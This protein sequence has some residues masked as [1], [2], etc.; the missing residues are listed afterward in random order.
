MRLVLPLI[1]TFIC[2]MLMILQF[3]IPHRPFSLLGEELSDW[4]MI[5]ASAAIFLGV[6]N[7]VQVHLM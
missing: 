5:V 3:F 1:V 6:V 2:G 7:L 4:Y